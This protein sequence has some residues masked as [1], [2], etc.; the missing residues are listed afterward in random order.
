MS[1]HSRVCSPNRSLRPEMARVAVVLMNLGGPD[2]LEAVR[3][4]LV[5]LFG[6]PAIIGLPGPLRWPLARLIAWRRTPIAQ[7]IYARLGGRSPLLANT[8]AQAQALEGAL[9]P[10]HRCFVAMR[11]WHPLSA[12]T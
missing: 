9:G 8:Q 4:F 12:E 2:S 5:N 1:R 3:P 10:G 6:D 11:Y 7:A